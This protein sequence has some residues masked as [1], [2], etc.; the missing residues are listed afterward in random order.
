M[1]K[2]VDHQQRR[3]QIAAA[4]LTVLSRDGLEGASLRHV[5]TEAGVTAGMVQ[6]YFPSKDSMLEF[7]MVEAGARYEHRMN[8]RLTRLGDDPEPA[9]VI[10]AL[11]G[12][13]LPADEAQSDD[14]RIAL[15]FQT[16]ATGHPPAASRLEQGN[17]LLRGHLA[18]LIAA[19]R[20]EL[21]DPAPLATALWAT[22]EGL[23]VHVLCSRLPLAE[24]QHALDRQ[25]ALVLG[26]D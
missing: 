5:A 4:L 2:V 24:A 21:P 15:A 19:V 22:A 20:P 13:L 26:R 6:H 9:S 25:L 16:Y 8:D 14:A 10:A 11:L 17:S 1:P 7:A 23:A 18:T 12:A 3:S